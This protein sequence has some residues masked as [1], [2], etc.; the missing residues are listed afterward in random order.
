LGRAATSTGL[1]RVIFET[2][3]DTAMLPG[4]WL[5]RMSQSSGEQMLELW[6]L[7]ISTA[8]GLFR[9]GHLLAISSR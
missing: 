2:V 7:L 8:P 3:Q 9:T 1:S 6:N 5:T 4:P